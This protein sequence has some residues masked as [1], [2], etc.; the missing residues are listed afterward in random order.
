[1]K[2]ALVGGPNSGESMDIPDGLTLLRVAVRD[3]EF[4][5]AGIA[6]YRFTGFAQ[7]SINGEVTAVIYQFDAWEFN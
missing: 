5:M 2:I 6:D 1:M 7:V 3:S 4:A